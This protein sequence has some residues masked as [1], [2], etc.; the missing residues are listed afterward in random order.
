[1]L[2]LLCYI[3][4]SAFFNCRSV[5]YS[6][7]FV[8][9]KKRQFWVVT[10][11][12][13]VLFTWL[14][15]ASHALTSLWSCDEGT[16][17][18]TLLSHQSN[19]VVLRSKMTVTD[20]PVIMWLQGILY[21]FFPQ[22]VSSNSYIMCCLSLKNGLGKAWF[23]HYHHLAVENVVHSVHSLKRVVPS[24]WCSELRCG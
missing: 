24:L 21:F 2:H 23:Y 14:S 10:S 1:M 9:T 19:I 17:Y 6:T 12:R 7:E 5:L 20:E 13:I 15:F 16:H 18:K 3:Y 4:L 22:P 11:D 8:G